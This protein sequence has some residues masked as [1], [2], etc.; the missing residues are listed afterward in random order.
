M[1]HVSKLTFMIVKFRQQLDTIHQHA[2]SLLRHELAHVATHLGEIL[3][4]WARA[5]ARTTAQ[6]TNKKPPNKKQ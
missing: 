4:D 3:P 6:D 1:R 2:D 5:T